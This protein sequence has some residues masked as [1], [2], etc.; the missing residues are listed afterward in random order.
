MG[1]RRRKGELWR[2]GRLKGWGLKEQG[3]GSYRD[4]GEKIVGAWERET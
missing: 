2:K 3:K 4:T 1:E